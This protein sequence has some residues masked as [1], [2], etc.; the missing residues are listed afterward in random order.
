[1]F[2][3]SVLLGS[4]TQKMGALWKHVDHVYGRCLL[5]LEQ[6]PQ[7][8]DAFYDICFIIFIYLVRSYNKKHDVG[9]LD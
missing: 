8:K 6:M 7:F 3:V 4:P 9:S 2:L 5:G 1:M